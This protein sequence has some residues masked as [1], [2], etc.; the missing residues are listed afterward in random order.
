MLW[1]W[2]GKWTVFLL[3]HVLRKSFYTVKKDLYSWAR[4]KKTLLIAI[5][6]QFR[7]WLFGIILSLLISDLETTRK[8]QFEFFN[9]MTMEFIKFVDPK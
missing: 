6:C 8:L 7:A 4:V 1:K 9:S 3:L 2:K 5:F